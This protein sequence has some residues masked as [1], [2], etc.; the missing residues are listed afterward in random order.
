MDIKESVTSLIKSLS[1]KEASE[2]ADH[3]HNFL[4]LDAYHSAQ[5][6]FNK[7]KAILT[8]NKTAKVEET[9]QKIEEHVKNIHQ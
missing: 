2:L 8:Q 9:Q 5:Q 7:L 6:S 3:N 1:Y 4:I